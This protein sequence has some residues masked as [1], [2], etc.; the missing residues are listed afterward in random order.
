[1]LAYSPPTQ[2]S[3]TMRPR[4][5]PTGDGDKVALV[6]GRGGGGNVEQ[7]PTPEA[8]YRAAQNLYASYYKLVI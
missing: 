1:M 6:R 3:T 4:A 5:T 2:P 8:V 7:L